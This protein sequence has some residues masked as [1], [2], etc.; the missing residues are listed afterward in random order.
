MGL[1][2]TVVE[3]KKESVTTTAAFTPTFTSETVSIP[4]PQPE[5]AATETVTTVTTE[6]STTPVESV[7]TEPTH[8]EPDKKDNL[9][10]EW[11]SCLKDI[12]NKQGDIY[13]L[14]YKAAELAQKLQESGQKT[15][16]DL[17]KEFGYILDVCIA[18]KKLDQF[19]KSNT[20]S[21]FAS[22]LGIYI[23]T[24]AD[25]YQPEAPGLSLQAEIAEIQRK[26]REQ[27]ELAHLEAERQKEEM[28][29]QAAINRATQQKLLT[30]S[31]WQKAKISQMEAEQRAATE[32]LRELQNEARQLVLE[33][34]KS[35]A[36]QKT[37]T[38]K[39]LLT[40]AKE[41]VTEL[42]WG[43][44]QP[45]EAAEQAI[46][47]KKKLLEQLNKQIVQE[48]EKLVGH[49]R[50]KTNQAKKV[51]EINA[52]KSH[53]M[54]QREMERQAQLHNEQHEIVM[55]ADKN[56]LEFQQNE[57]LNFMNYIRN[58]KHATIVDNNQITEQAIIKAESIIKL[59]SRIPLIN[60]V[61]LEQTLKGT[62]ITALLDQQR[63]NQY[64]LYIFGNQQNFDNAI[65]GIIA[66]L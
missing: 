30:E 20:L 47:E 15:S 21:S 9:I 43:P 37:V 22:K 59:A 19:G 52:Q 27:E 64:H 35:T 8:V 39:S 63:G 61:Q 32:K 45:K 41:K 10:E 16:N 55:I 31:Q 48:E 62:F 36:E 44:T 54:T 2:E 18:Q 65:N 23:P 53:E 42:V 7:I 56:N 46:A 12:K 40:R 17:I 6:P 29:K 28:I 5:T 3:N 66:T 58:M 1:P 50:L 51:E 25:Q 33:L 4:E 11:N 26:Q 13:E 24:P 60:M 14:A 49:A 34:K 38:E 57:W